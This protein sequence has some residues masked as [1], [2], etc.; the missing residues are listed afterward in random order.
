[1]EVI[2]WVYQRWGRRH[3]AMVANV[4]RYRA[5]SAVRE[6]G[7]VL[8]LPQTAIDRVAKLSSHW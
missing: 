2:Q 8:G 7:K 3:A 4:I 6:V 5:R 1:E